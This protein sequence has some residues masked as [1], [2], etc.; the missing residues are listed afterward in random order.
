ME[1]FRQACES[2]GID[3]A[4]WEDMSARLDPSHPLWSNDRPSPFPYPSAHSP[5]PDEPS[6]IRG[7]HSISLSTRLIPSGPWPADETQ[8]IIGGL[9]RLLSSYFW[10][11]TVP[12]L[13]MKGIEEERA[14]EIVDRSLEELMDD[15]Y[16]SY[17]KCKIWTAR[18]I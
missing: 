7:F 18:R 6:P 13:M 10:R 11:A 12:M 8:R 9:S 2:Q 1:I 4:P 15:R 14:Q 5:K 16:R 17:L 3:L